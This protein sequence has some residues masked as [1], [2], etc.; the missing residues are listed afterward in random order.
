MFKWR[1]H[2]D[3]PVDVRL[4]VARHVE[5]EDVAHLDRVKG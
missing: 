5:V 3:T 2:K 4:D 1:N